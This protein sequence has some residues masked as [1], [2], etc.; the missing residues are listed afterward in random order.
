MYFVSTYSI[1]DLLCFCNTLDGN[2]INSW[3]AMYYI[4]LINTL[5]VAL[6]TYTY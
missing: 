1:N 6:Y 2:L 5:T 4:L 3:C